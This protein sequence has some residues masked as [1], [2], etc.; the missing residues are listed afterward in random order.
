[1]AGGFNCL[2]CIHC[3]FFVGEA[4]SPIVF[5]WEK[6]LLE[7]LL[8]QAGLPAVFRPVEAYGPVGDDEC[9]V[10]VL[11]RWVLRGFCPFYDSWNRRCVIHDFKPLACRMFPL[12]LE[13][14]SGRLLMSGVCDAVPKPPARVDE[15]FRDEFRAAVT[16]ML[17]YSGMVEKLSGLGRAEPGRC[18][19]FVDADI[20]LGLS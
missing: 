6:R 15:F 4:E 7:S 19:C 3:C 8:S 10:A 14:P 13:L 9:C 16:V 20:Y 11:Y 2:H 12:L 5:P 1:M 18:R 17:L